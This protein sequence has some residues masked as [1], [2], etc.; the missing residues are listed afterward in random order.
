MNE[1]PLVTVF[2]A[3]YNHVNY[4][5]DALCGFVNQKTDFRYV[6]YVRDDASSD[7]TVDI[8]K[9]YEVRYPDLIKVFYEKE[10]QHS[11]GKRG[12][13][14][15][16]LEMI[17]S[18]YVALCEG[19]DYWIDPLK[20]QIQVNYLE[21]HPDCVMTG[22]NGLNLDCR[23][24]KMVSNDGFA[25]EQDVSMV[26]V[27]KRKKMCFPTAS[28]VM[29]REI[30][31]REPFFRECKT[32][33]W[34]MQLYAATK[35]KIHYFDRI[36]SV[37]RFFAE[38]S[39]TSRTYNVPI[40]YVVYMIDMSRFFERF[41]EY[42]NKEYSSI[43]TAMISGYIKEAAG[44]L[45]QDMLENVNEFKEKVASRFKMDISKQIDAVIK[46]YYLVEEEKKHILDMAKKCKS[47]YVMGTGNR[48]A[49]V[50]SDFLDKNEVHY[51]GY[52]VS[53]GQTLKSSFRGKPVKYLS[54]ITEE[55]DDC[56][57]IIA[58]KKRLKEEIEESLNGKGIKNYC[59]TWM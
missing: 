47:V 21:S 5:E 23:T 12:Q 13:I 42:T 34:M 31:F 3:T 15:Q 32:G 24:G 57:V 6:V 10:N 36:M 53:D 54:E 30:Y 58:I 50:V 55:R 45:S 20:L 14:P 2:C 22:H 11:Q 9:E 8:L 37:Y 52:V 7:G 33:D 51:E 35:G 46:E 43:I 27:L 29:R 56:C 19:D 1:N 49:D 17:K 40:E 25:G 16:I 4:I 26:D 39:W 28:F 18:K 38:G 48:G 59:W 41:D 44:A